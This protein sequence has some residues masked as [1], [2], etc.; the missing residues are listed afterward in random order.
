MPAVSSEENPHVLSERP[1]LQA[2]LAG[3]CKVSSKSRDE[4][5]EAVVL[6]AG[7]EQDRGEAEVQDRLERPC[8]LDRGS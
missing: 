7:I 4:A 2:K 3:P 6:G 8:V 5:A 1:S